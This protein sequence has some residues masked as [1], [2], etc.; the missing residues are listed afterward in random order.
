ME[1]NEREKANRHYY[2][3]LPDHMKVAA[4]VGQI[5]ELAAKTWTQW[6]DPDL[7]KALSILDKWVNRK[8]KEW[9]AAAQKQAEHD[10]TT[11]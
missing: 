10:A 8:D 1:R 2:Q 6:K 5:R 3:A 4:K 9:T 7:L 11:G